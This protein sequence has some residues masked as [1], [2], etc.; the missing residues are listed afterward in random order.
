MGDRHLVDFLSHPDLT[1]T[2]ITSVPGDLHDRTWSPRLIR[3]ALEVSLSSPDASRNDVTVVIPQYLL[4]MA[5]KD[6]K[7]ALEVVI[8]Y[9]EGPRLEQPLFIEAETRP[10]GFGKLLLIGAIVSSLVGFTG[11]QVAES[12]APATVTEVT[13]SSGVQTMSAAELIQTIKTENRTVYWLNSKQG[14]SYTNS[15]S[16][17]GIDQIFYRPV[18]SSASDL[19]QFDVNVGTYRDYSTYDA[20]PHPFLGANGRTITLPS[21]AT[22]TYNTASPNQAVVQF[23]N[24]PEVVVLNY[25]ATQTVPTIINDAESLVPI[26]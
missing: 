25:P 24:K 8:P 6:S 12:H 11:L 16:A 26:S 23:S 2:P 17:N 9:D 4:D 1:G 15:S 22:V 13:V 3:S 21:G 20:Q 18:G 10:I 14:E 19:K 5:L 7:V